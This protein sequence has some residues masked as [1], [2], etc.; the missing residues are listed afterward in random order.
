MA[1]YKHDIVEADAIIQWYDQAG[2]VGWCRKFVEWLREEDDEGESDDD[3]DV[4]EEGGEEVDEVDVNY[5]VEDPN[6]ESE[7]L[8]KSLI[9]NP[10]LK[11][12]SVS[13]CGDG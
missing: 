7:K 9:A 13:F 11:A 3:N 2:S 4:E 8:R 1:L 6:I 5:D 12:R 10:N